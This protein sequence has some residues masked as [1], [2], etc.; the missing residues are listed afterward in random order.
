[1]AKLTNRQTKE[2]DRAVEILSKD[3]LTYDDKIFV[4]ENWREDHS[5]NTGVA[6]AFFTPPTL[7]RDLS[8]EVP[9]GCDRII[10][11]CAGIGTLSFTIFQQYKVSGES[12]EIVC[13]ELNPDYVELGKKILPEATWIQGSALDKDL[14]KSLGSF[15]CA[16]SNPPFGNVKTG[17]QKHW[18]NYT[19]SGFEFKIVEIASVISD[20]GVFILPQMSCGFEYSGKQ[21]FSKNES[22]AYQKFNKQTELTLSMNCGF[23]TSAY[24]SDWHGVK[25]VVE[26]A[27]CD[28]SG[29]YH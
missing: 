26:I 2:H 9:G 1:M 16:V 4:L 10:D 22:N 12:L 28:Y 6:G 21:G 11:L 14:I 5:H 19:G 7:A 27:L 23:D 20:Y 24:L 29:M 18:L 3:N 13:V 8:I 17:I 15:C 25:P